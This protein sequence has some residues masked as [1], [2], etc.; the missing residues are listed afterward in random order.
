L[1]C[2]HKTVCASNK[3]CS[4]VTTGLLRRALTQALNF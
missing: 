1:N 4:P 2:L 3:L